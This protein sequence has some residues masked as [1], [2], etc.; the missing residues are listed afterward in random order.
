MTSSDA[1]L[2]NLPKVL[3]TEACRLHR[4]LH[5][6]GKYFLVMFQVSGIRKLLKTVI[7]VNPASKELIA[8]AIKIDVS[9]NDEKE[10]NLIVDLCVKGNGTTD[11]MDV[12]RVYRNDEPLNTMGYSSCPSMDKCSRDGLLRN[13]ISFP[14]TQSDLQGNARL[15]SAKPIVISDTDSASSG[16]LI[17]KTPLITDN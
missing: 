10:E 17:T 11:C 3:V 5:R 8:D 9:G 14:V 15:I 12:V 13:N 7:S 2:A 4:R 6:L 16:A 1:V